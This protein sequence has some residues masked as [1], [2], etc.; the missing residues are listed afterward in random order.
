MKSGVQNR[1]MRNG[2]VIGCAIGLVLMLLAACGSPASPSSNEGDDGAPMAASESADSGGSPPAETGSGSGA[3]GSGSKGSSVPAPVEPSSSPK[4]FSPR[5]IAFSTN[6]MLITTQKELER[7][8]KFMEPWDKPMREFT[9]GNPL[10][11]MLGLDAD[12]ILAELYRKAGPPTY[13]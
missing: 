5:M 2:L 7:I 10:L 9:K 6:I 8:K 12:R 4:E 1:T 3:S 11:P 13:T